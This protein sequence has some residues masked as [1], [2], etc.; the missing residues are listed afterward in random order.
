M[1]SL[2]ILAYIILALVWVFVVT[3][4]VMEELLLDSLPYI[5][6]LL[7][8]LMVQSVIVTLVGFLWAIFWAL[9]RVG[10]F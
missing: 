4:L 6:S 3:P 9:H 7:E 8:G 1:E 5:D 10:L 2:D